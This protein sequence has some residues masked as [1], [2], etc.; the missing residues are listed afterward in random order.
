M[1]KV[2]KS[3]MKRCKVDSFANLEMRRYT[4]KSP[5]KHSFKDALYMTLHYK[6]QG[7][8]NSQKMRWM[9]VDCRI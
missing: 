1:H 8:R 7:K 3:K 5:V 4:I 2:V 9:G 6:N